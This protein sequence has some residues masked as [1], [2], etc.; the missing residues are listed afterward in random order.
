MTTIAIDPETAIQQTVDRYMKLAK[1]ES[2]VIESAVMRRTLQLRGRQLTHTDYKLRLQY[3][4]AVK[5]EGDA[6]DALIAARNSI[7]ESDTPR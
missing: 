7:A 6:I 4:N 1:L 3:S 2:A 5:A